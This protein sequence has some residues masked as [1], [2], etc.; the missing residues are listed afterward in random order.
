MPISNLIVY[1]DGSTKSLSIFS[2]LNEHISHLLY[3]DKYVVVQ[4]ISMYIIAQ[5]KTE[6][7]PNLLFLNCVFFFCVQSR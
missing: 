5:N 1:I 3:L 4:Q 7:R 6:K 2:A